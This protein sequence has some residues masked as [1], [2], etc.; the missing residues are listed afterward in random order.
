MRRLYTSSLARALSNGALAL[1]ATAVLLGG[2]H[3][4]TKD[5]SVTA[6]PQATLPTS[7]PSPAPIKAVFF[8]DSIVAGANAGVGNPTFVD[9]TSKLLGWSSSPFGFPGSGFT[10]AGTF[11][12]GRDYLARVQQLKGFDVD[13]VVLEGGRN[14]SKAPADVLRA[15]IIEV[16]DALGTLVPRARVVLMG[17]YSPTGAVLDSTLQTDIVMRALAREQKTPYVDPVLE[18]WI[19]GTYPSSGNA[20][21]LIARDGLY[22][23]Q[24]GHAYFGK[25][26]A[27]DLRKLLPSSLVRPLEESPQPAG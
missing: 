9:V 4:V 20:A 7:S 24:A 11:R 17:P 19:T 12:G 18:G 3:V 8:G 1:L 26:L 21:T 10:T 6:N 22:P 2:F 13:V 14:D 23:N 16:L 15:K 25:R 27:A 5:R